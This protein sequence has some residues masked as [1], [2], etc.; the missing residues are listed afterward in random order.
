[1]HN[2]QPSLQS[3]S[4]I[5]IVT[6]PRRF[7]SVLTLVYFMA[8]SQLVLT[9]GIIPNLWA[10]NS[11]GSTPVLVSNSTSKIPLESL[12]K[13]N[14]SE[15]EIAFFTLKLAY[16]NSGIHDGESGQGQG[17]TNGVRNHNS[18]PGL[19]LIRMKVQAKPSRRTI[20][21][22]SSKTRECMLANA[23]QHPDVVRLINDLQNLAKDEL[24][25]FLRAITQWIW[26][27]SELYVWVTVLDRFDEIMADLITQYD[28]ANIQ[29]TPYSSEDKELLYQILRFERML[30][31][32][33]TNR[34]LFSSYD[35]LS[36]FVMSPD[37]DIAIEALGLILRPAHQ[38]TSQMSLNIVLRVNHAHLECLA[39]SW[40]ALREYSTSYLKLLSPQE[41][42]VL[43]PEASD[44]HF[45]WYSPK[46]VTSDHGPHQIHL[47]S[48][49]TDTRDCMTILQDAVGGRA[50]GLSER[51]DLMCRIRIAKSLGKGQ[52][53]L[54]SKL[55]ILRLLAI[56]VYCHTHTESAGQNAKLLQESDI[57]SSTAPLLAIDKGIH[58]TVQAAAVHA[59]DGLCHHR[60]R[61]NEVLTAVNVSVAHGLLMSLFR[62]TVSVLED[63]TKEPP[64]PLFDAL[65]TFLD[66]LTT[67]EISY[68]MII[69]AGLIDHLKKIIADRQPSHATLVAKTIPLLDNA[70]YGPPPGPSSTQRNNS[71][72]TTFMSDNG[73]QFLLERIKYEVDSTIAKF[74]D[75]KNEE[76]VPLG[77]GRA[78]AP[79]VNVLKHLLRTIQRMIQSPGSAEVLRLLPE[80]DSA[81]IPTLKNILENRH[82]FGSSV[83]AIAML[84][85][86]GWVH[87]EPSSLAIIQ[88]NKLPES[89]YALVERGIEPMIEVIHGVLN[90]MGALSLNQAGQSL[91]ESRADVIGTVF[92][93]FTSELH[94]SALQ[95]KSN[96]SLVGGDVDE[97]VRHHPWLKL[98]IFKAITDVLQ[99]IKTLGIEYM[100]RIGTESSFTLVST[101]KTTAENN[102]SAST[103]V[104]NQPVISTT[105]TTAGPSAN[106]QPF[107]LSEMSPY[108][109]LNHFA[110]FL[111]GFFNHAQHC[112]DILT[113]TEILKLFD[114]ILTLPSWPIEL[115][116]GRNMDAILLVNRRLMDAS[117]SIVLKHRIQEVKS[118]LG[119]GDKNEKDRRYQTSITKMARYVSEKGDNITEAQAAFGDIRHLFIH[120][121]LLNDV[122]SQASSHSI[123]QPFRREPVNLL[124]PLAEDPTLISQMGELSKVSAWEILQLRAYIVESAAKAPAKE[125]PQ[126]AS[127]TP[128][129]AGTNVTPPEQS[130]SPSLGTDLFTFDPS[131]RKRSQN[132][133]DLKGKTAPEDRNFSNVKYILQAL[134][135]SLQSIFSGIAKSL[136]IPRR[137]A[138]S[139]VSQF[140]KDSK[141]V[142]KSLATTLVTLLRSYKETDDPVLAMGFCALAISSTNCI[143]PDS[144]QGFNIQT[145]LF[146]EFQ[147]EG[148]I[149]AIIQI[150]GDC[151]DILDATYAKPQEERS[152]KD[153]EVMAVA[154]HFLRHPLLWFFHLASGKSLLDSAQTA[155]IARSNVY[156]GFTPKDTLIRLRLELLPLFRRLW[157][158][159]WLLETSESVRRA[160]ILGLL[161]ILKGEFEDSIVPASL[162]AAS[163]QPQ[164]IRRPIQ[165]PISPAM[166]QQLTDMGF[167]EAAARSALTRARGNLAVATELLLTNA[168]LFSEDDN[169]PIQPDAADPQAVPTN[170]V[171]PDS[172]APSEP[173]EPSETPEPPADIASTN[174]N[175]G[176][177]AEPSE[178]QIPDSDTTK[179]DYAKELVDAREELKNS[180][181]PTALRLADANPAFIDDIRDV[182]IGPSL[183]GNVKTLVDDIKSFCSDDADVPEVPFLVRCRILALAYLKVGSKGLGFSKEDV[184]ELLQRLLN[185]LSTMSIPG[186]SETS[187]PK[188]VSSVLLL[189]DRILCGAED[190]SPAT[191]PQNNDPI[192]QVDLFVGPD[193]TDAKKT[194]FETGIRLVRISDL[195]KD[196]LSSLLGIFATLT[197]NR[198]MAL[199]FIK[200]DG[201]NLLLQHFKKNRQSE[202]ICAASVAILRHIMEDRVV[203]EDIMRRDLKRWNSVPRSR[204]GENV[205]TYVRSLQHAALREPQSFIRVTSQVCELA[206]PIPGLSGGYRL[207]PREG[208]LAPLDESLTIAEDPGYDGPYVSPEDA[209]AEV[210]LSVIHRL[211]NEMTQQNKQNA[212]QSSST[213]I[214]GMSLLATGEILSP[215][216]T[217]GATTS[218]NNTPL[219]V[220]SVLPTVS[221]PPLLFPNTKEL[222]YSRYVQ[223]V[224]C[225]LLLCYEA[226][227]TAFLTFPRRRLPTSSKDTTKFKPLALSFLLQEIGSARNEG[228][229]WPKRRLKPSA[230]QSMIVSLCADVGLTIDMKEIPSSIVNARKIVLD[231]LLKALK[232]PPTPSETLDQR[233]GRYISLADLCQKLLTIN[234]HAMPQKSPDESL[235]HIAQLMLEK[236][237][238]STFASVLSEIDLAHPLASVVTSYILTPLE[239][240]T[241]ASIKLGR[242]SDQ[243]TA[244][245]VE[246]ERGPEFISESDDGS[247]LSDAEELPDPYSTSALGMYGGETEG[248]FVDVEEPVGE[249]EEE[250]GD[251]EM[252]YGENEYDTE[253]SQDE[254]GDVMEVASG[255]EV[256][257]NED[258]ETDPEGGDDMDAVGDEEGD[259]EDEDEN[260]EDE[261]S[262]SDGEGGQL[263]DDIWQELEVPRDENGVLL[264]EADDEEDIVVDGLHDTLGNLSYA[265]DGDLGE[266]P[267][268]VHPP[269]PISMEEIHPFPPASRFTA[270]IGTMLEGVVNMPPGFPPMEGAPVFDFFEDF[271][272]TAF[273][274]GFRAPQIIRTSTL[275]EMLGGPTAQ[276]I[277]EMGRNHNGDI[278]LAISGP[279]AHIIFNDAGFDP[280]Q[281]RHR[282]MSR[283]VSVRSG[284]GTSGRD[285]DQFVSLSTGQRWSEEARINAGPSFD[286]RL[287]ELSNHVIVALLPAARE[288]ARIQEEEAEKQRKEAEEKE[289]VE[290]EAKEKAEAEER[291]RAEAEAALELQR[292]QERL[293]AMNTDDAEPSV[294]TSGQMEDATMVSST[295]PI[296]PS[297]SNDEIPAQPEA[298]SSSR[299]RV[300]VMYQ[301]E[302]VDIT[303]ADIDPEFLNAVP[304]DIR[305]EI[306]GNFVREQQRQ[307]RP[308][309]TEEVEMDTDFLSALPADIR[310]DVLRHHTLTQLATAVGAVDMDPASVLAT[311]PEEL[312]QTVLLEQDDAILEAMPSSVLAEATALRQRIARR[313]MP[314]GTSLVIDE[315]R[316]PIQTHSTRKPQVRET[317]QLLDKSGMAS[318]VRL[319]FFVDQNRRTSLQQVLVNLCENGK[320]RTD[321]LNILLSLLHNGRNELAG[322]DQSFSQMSVKSAK[323]SSK[324]KQREDANTVSGSNER[325]P[326]EQVVLHRALDALMSIVHANDAASM[327]FLTEQE[328]T[329]NL[330]RTS[331]KKGKGKEKVTATTHYPFVQLLTL[332][333]RPGL[334]QQAHS[335]DTISGLLCTVTKPL[336]ALRLPEKQIPPASPPAGADAPVGE[337]PVVPT[338]PG[339]EVGPGPLRITTESTPNDA[340]PSEDAKPSNDEP[341]PVSP[342]PQSRDDIIRSK[343][344]HFPDA[345]LR[346]VVNL[347]TM[348]E[349][350]SRCFQNTQMLIFNLSSL[351]GVR[352]TIIEELCAKAEDFGRLILLELEALVRSIH[353][354]K[355][356]EELP[357]LITTKFS[358]P[359][360]NQARLLRILKILENIYMP[361]LPGRSTTAVDPPEKEANLVAIFQRLNFANLWRKLSDCLKAV[362]D[363]ADSTHVATFLLPLMESL[364]VVCKFTAVHS[365]TSSSKVVRASASPRSPTLERDSP[366]DIFVAFTDK[367]RKALNLMI[368]NKPSLMFGS[369]SLL[370][371]NPRVLDFDNKR[372]YF[373]HKLRHKSRSERERIS[374]SSIPI[375]VRRAKVFE[376]S[377]QAITRLNERDLKYGKLNVR[378]TNEEGVDA[379]GVT[380][381]WFRILAR[382]IFNPNYALFSPC[383]AD[384][385]TYQPNPASWINPDHLRYFKFVGRILGKAIYDQK[386]LDGHFARS[387]YRQLLGKPVDYRDLEWSDPSYY[388]GL[389]WMLDNS[390][391]AMDLT[392]SEQNDQLG[393]MIIVDLKPNGRN[394]P[395]TDEN[396]DEYIQLI[397]EYRL[398]TSIKDQLA[399][400]L[401]GFYEIVPKEHIAIF[402]EKEVELLISGTPEIDVE[403][404]RSATEYH[405][406]SASDA[407]IVWWWRALKSFSRA[408]RAKVLSFAT[409]TAKVPL[410]GFAELQGVDGVQRFSIHKDYGVM[411]RLP[412]AHTC[413]NQIDLPQYSSYEKL[414][415]Q[416]LLAINEGGEGFGFA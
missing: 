258:D 342:T 169:P 184:T 229:D 370:V 393:Q 100:P 315:I 31:D 347:L 217:A 301:G 228:A 253:G 126:G 85:I 269:Q 118:I 297:Q 375:N 39:R 195:Q 175:A 346:L 88:E 12:P 398:T 9:S 279:A 111:T 178:Q 383:G 60:F 282:L 36:I 354:T 412:Q 249:E 72:F 24:A 344:P 29:L 176:S 237:F 285:G 51:L 129:Q 272:R 259:E 204:P 305:D 409:G 236:N 64:Y 113:D 81:F 267:V 17:G 391:E 44:V 77:Y 134:S 155:E 174:E 274:R 377:F 400:F 125:P 35:R 183:R 26:P 248:A 205:V 359:T 156:E 325:G 349:C 186:S 230:L 256:D 404:W 207:R 247:G 132:L 351:P 395:V 189:C 164:I 43:P 50:I 41:E 135:G 232:E 379:G 84:V 25:P 326:E 48:L 227:K 329:S 1:M 338:E 380:R 89:F 212:E 298:S 255:E 52:V 363:R 121:I 312:R 271:G 124:S 263:G 119:S 333:E 58:E 4:L 252:E 92:G 95:E 45:Q 291:A 352:Q 287:G 14:A 254:E 182:F 239:T 327:F 117:P 289:R 3:H 162:F 206:E 416:L 266:A 128:T 76:S 158:T 108:Q 104:G 46:S 260:S 415:Q 38:Y 42:R 170:V 341:K 410:G 278:Q 16:L 68:S 15:H 348:G 187:L 67:H 110:K 233:Y 145:G 200:Q 6:Q 214:G 120:L 277:Q 179:R 257:P 28:A 216:A 54:R 173:N 137:L 311:F 208:E 384:R 152:N 202:E 365:L 149:E 80:T 168:H 147:R 376:D 290:Q 160:V 293:S 97:L 40:P 334:L 405:G 30:L 306:I 330:H 286:E 27:R 215:T 360:S 231:N 103:E 309:R 56:A 323:S 318:L 389:R 99:S 268:F 140:K 235:I 300:T 102:P 69:G 53:E 243:S 406:Y 308:V 262:V 270:D 107:E 223:N 273:R 408:D 372:S 177:S 71:P 402:D 246:D 414:R 22:V 167:Q 355:R 146:L 304:E 57:V 141:E 193:L 397:A 369:F 313:G 133:H 335:L 101:P 165:P 368:R 139:E 203:I 275:Q 373:V 357:S 47:V 138:S 55:V 143:G 411:D 116:M 280:S 49:S 340:A 292:E 13:I 190:I 136:S 191:V 5:K 153:K 106:S 396:K 224:L 78:S 294:A 131:S 288:A 201:V 210:A 62:K 324:G 159:S 211:V 18:S 386:L 219:Q 151:A 250:E 87:N 59:L 321:T 385:L 185:V 374:Y 180:I 172:N 112:R 90:A 23:V 86:S 8:S 331:S 367:H 394:I 94:M 328:T 392:F 109:Y 345:S 209:M 7:I 2:E 32:N 240:L 364:M 197:R 75:V 188:W 91:L 166:I 34:K 361:S 10:M 407:V 33:S 63:P 82:L 11:S 220:S 225:E 317:A 198:R 399:A 157:E 96:A 21:P 403:D 310:E 382:E 413:F 73:I 150:C 93:I 194:L 79:N 122:Y 66:F 276:M 251:I 307:S 114:G 115:T 70:L 242:T 181:V 366:G 74:K 381:E 192:E 83:L 244:P 283:Y 196:D 171:P 320:S 37:V 362:E 265:L 358:L 296:Q 218:G 387:V 378:F 213:P 148:G 130:Q 319:L 281:F 123:H 350:S 371:Q 264:P 245:D 161:A 154:H 299:P 221:Q 19:C 127:S 356:G 332:L 388:S 284:R 98:S 316:Q 390:V 343:P 241:K 353:S 339:S 302:S 163:D 314:P 65:Q 261:D 222:D 142:T 144:R 295:E 336:T 199:Q 20:P 238:V 322:I 226:C 303:D 61:S 401:E 105:P 337:T 234:P